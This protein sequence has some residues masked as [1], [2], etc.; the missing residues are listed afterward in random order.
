MIKKFGLSFLFVLFTGT[1]IS[2]QKAPDRNG[3]LVG[4][5]K[6]IDFQQAPFH[7]WFDKEYEDYQPKQS[8]V[9]KIKKELEGIDIKIFMGSW[10][11]DSHREIPRFFKL[12]QLTDFDVQQHLEIIGLT[13]GKK[14]PDNLQQGFDI[15]HTPT[16]IFYRDGKEIGRYIEHSRQ[17]M[18]KDFLKIL[19]GKPYKHS[20]AK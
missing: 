12:M 9:N 1:I 3:N 19:K 18:E 13:R 14:T 5:L 7:T 10:C 15:Q 6:K 17:S 20:Y 2:A 4:F 8:V 11:H 16:F